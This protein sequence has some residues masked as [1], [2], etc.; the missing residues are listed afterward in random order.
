MKKTNKG[1]SMVELIIVIAI[2]AILA[3]AIAPAL[4]K[5]INKSRL[6]SDV[7]NAQTIASAITSALAD[8]D[9][10]TAAKPVLTATDLATA[11]GTSGDFAEAV[12][13]ALSAYDSMKIKAKKDADNGTF[14]TTNYLVTI[15]P[16]T[17]TVQVFVGDEDH[18]A[19]PT[20]D[21]NLDKGSKKGSKE[22]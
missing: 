6:S 13:E 21:D 16:S 1:F 17:S 8:E 2:M 18:M 12:K 4:I 22:D 9:G 7:S 10:F 15:D 19:Y 5:Y 11:V 3:G 14:K 20:V